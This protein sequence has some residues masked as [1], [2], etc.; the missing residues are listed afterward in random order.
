M[1]SM[2]ITVIE[3]LQQ[4]LHFGYG[5]TDKDSES[6]VVLVCNKWNKKLRADS[7][8]EAHLLN[9]TDIDLP[10]ANFCCLNQR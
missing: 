3:K 2:Q 8:E 1:P 6:F 9:E 7:N 5:T 10:L 4:L